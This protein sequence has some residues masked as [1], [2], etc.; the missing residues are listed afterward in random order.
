MIIEAGSLV[1][2][3]GALLPSVTLAFD[4]FSFVTVHS[5]E[6]KNTIFTGLINAASSILIP[7][8]GFWACALSEFRARVGRD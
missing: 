2:L 8:V 7:Q 5:R 6:G 1:T 3:L 4:C